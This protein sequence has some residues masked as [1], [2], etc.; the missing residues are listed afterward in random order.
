[1]PR[2]YRRNNRVFGFSYADPVTAPITGPGPTAKELIVPQ[3]IEWPFAADDAGIAYPAGTVGIRSVSPGRATEKTWGTPGGP[4]EGLDKW[5][6]VPDT[7]PGGYTLR[8]SRDVSRGP[9]V[10]SGDP[11]DTTRGTP[12]LE[13]TWNGLG[14]FNAAGAAGNYS[15]TANGYESSAAY[16]INGLAP[17]TVTFFCP[18]YRP[19]GGGGI[20]PLSWVPMGFSQKVLT[21]YMYNQDRPPL[22]DLDASIAGYT[23]KS[24]GAWVWTRRDVGFRNIVLPVLVASTP[25]TW[26]AAANTD[27]AVQ[28]TV[29]SNATGLISG[30]G[31]AADYLSAV[32]HKSDFTFLQTIGL[33][34]YYT[35]RHSVPNTWNRT[36][37]Q[38][39]WAYKVGFVVATQASLGS[40]YIPNAVGA[41]ISVYHQPGYRLSPRCD[42]PAWFATYGIGVGAPGGV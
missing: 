17:G 41:G 42:I 33:F 39:L 3:C 11:E 9:C 4:F 20:V 15:L 8:N 36:K 12:W 32:Y 38:G 24:A 21:C 30:E 37:A 28:F 27:I 31:T 16:L 34:D 14:E 5:F 1:M 40:V 2:F 6:P 13:V 10:F 22:V 19:D 23:N 18:S 25:A 7:L 29:R 35:L 26:A